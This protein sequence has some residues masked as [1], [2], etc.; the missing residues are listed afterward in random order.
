MSSTGYE[1]CG[2]RIVGIGK[3]REL[4]RHL[5]FQVKLAGAKTLHE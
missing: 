5:D 3:L 2:S 1:E 4:G